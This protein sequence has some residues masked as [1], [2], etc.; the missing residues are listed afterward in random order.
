MVAGRLRSGEAWSTA[1]VQIV[2][3]GG[4]TTPGVV[5]LCGPRIAVLGASTMIWPRVIGSTAIPAQGRLLA[6]NRADIP[7]PAQGL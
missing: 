2:G 7:S 3:G 4:A 1:R 5:G 6:H